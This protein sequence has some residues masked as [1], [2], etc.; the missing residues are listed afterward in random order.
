MSAN[1]DGGTVG[2]KSCRL[3]DPCVVGMQY[4]GETVSEGWGRGESWRGGIEE[5]DVLNGNTSHSYSIYFH[6][7]SLPYIKGSFYEYK[8]SC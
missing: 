1:I 2:V 3:L 6:S 5:V 7:L 8:N 4:T